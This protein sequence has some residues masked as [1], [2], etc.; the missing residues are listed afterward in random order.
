MQSFKKWMSVLVLSAMISLTGCGLVE[1]TPEGGTQL[2][3][4]GIQ[5]IDGVVAIAEPV[6]N[7]VTSLGLFWP[8]ATALGGLI[9]GVAGTWKK[10]KP[11]VEAAKTSEAL[12]ESAG[13]AMVLA[14]EELK[15][16]SPDSWEKLKPLLE[17]FIAAGGTV[18]SFIRALRELPPKV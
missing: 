6:G 3:P 18:E 7:L 12:A 2:S 10:L 1:K 15:K 17:D 14:I 13:K 5:K 11:E 16:A 9:A 4:E 8:G